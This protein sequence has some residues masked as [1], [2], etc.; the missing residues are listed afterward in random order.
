MIK[1][2][3]TLVIALALPSMM[4]GQTAQDVWVQKTYE[5]MSLEEKI[6][7][8]FTISFIHRP[9]QGRRDMLF[10]R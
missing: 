10:S 6:G 8:L 2:I 5:S 4:M 9:V 3:A 7:Q 1:I